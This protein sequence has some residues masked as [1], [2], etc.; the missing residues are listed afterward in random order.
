MKLPTVDRF[1]EARA[2]ES[3][4]ETAVAVKRGLGLISISLYY[5]RSGFLPT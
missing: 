2:E 3:I 4:G 5:H 1:W